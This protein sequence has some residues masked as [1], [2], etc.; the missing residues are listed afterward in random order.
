MAEQEQLKR[1]EVFYRGKTLEYLKDLDIRESS[2]FLSSR[3]R[4][5]VLK[6]FDKIAQF[7]ERCQ[8]KIGHNKKIRT[9]L[10]DIV[11]VPKLVGYTI[12]VHN[13]RNFHEVHITIEMIDHRLGEFAPTRSKVAHSAAG[14]GAT[15]S[16]RA[17]KK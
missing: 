12:L 15:K 1:K 7:V 4:R 2:K 8:E 13:G 9:H 14:I 10:R 6:N 11:I 3:N 17:K 16:S 5:A